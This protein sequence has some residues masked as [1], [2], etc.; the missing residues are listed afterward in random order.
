VAPA[1]V[2]FPPA[3]TAPVQFNGAPVEVAPAPAPK[4]KG[5]RGKTKGTEPVVYTVR[6]IGDRD[7]AE[8]REAIAPWSDDIL[9]GPYL[10]P[11]VQQLRAT[12]P[13]L[14]PA[15]VAKAVIEARVKLGAAGQ[16]PPAL[17][18]F[19]A[20][21]FEVLAYRLFPGVDEQYLISVVE[22]LEEATGTTDE[23]EEEDE[24]DE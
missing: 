14:D 1:V 21:Q 15:D 23:D 9:F 16:T 10:L 19:D 17:E 18:L 2:S 7:P 20:K 3:A 24:S 11:Y 6:D 4:A 5:K 13:L 22:A 8:V 12:D